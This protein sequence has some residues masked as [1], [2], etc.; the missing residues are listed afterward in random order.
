MFVRHRTGLLV[1]VLVHRFAL[2]CLLRFVRLLHTATLPTVRAHYVYSVRLHGYAPFAQFVCVCLDT[3]ILRI[4]AALVYRYHVC[5]LRLTFAHVCRFGCGFGC[6]YHRLLRVSFVYVAVGSRLGLHVYY[7]RCY[8]RILRFT[9][10]TVWITTFQ[11]V[12]FVA[13]CRIDFFQRWL[14]Y[15]HALYPT[16]LFVYCT[17]RLL[18]VYFCFTALVCRLLVGY[19]CTRIYTAR[20][21]SPLHALQ[22]HVGLQFLRVT[23]RST[24]VSQFTTLFWLI[25]HALH[26]FPFGYC[27]T[28]RLIPVDFGCRL[29]L[30][31]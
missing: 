21:C 31:D 10:Y 27:R 5:I 15:A 26:G 9:R 2:H 24:V 14:F 20:V 11:L 3:L 29:R 8:A 4:H 12:T 19:F 17:P 6:C 13:F 23:L 28:A 16:L 30:F 18:T 22:L 1:W 7:A 25:Y